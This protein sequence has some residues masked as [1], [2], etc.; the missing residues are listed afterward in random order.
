MESETVVTAHDTCIIIIV[1]LLRINQYY[2]R[3]INFRLDKSSQISRF[4]HTKC[5]SFHVFTVFWAR[6]IDSE[7][8][9]EYSMT[10]E[11]DRNAFDFVVNNL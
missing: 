4:F 9:F 2:L 8:K 10:D 5:N 11:E 7:S 3:W 1:Y 6:N